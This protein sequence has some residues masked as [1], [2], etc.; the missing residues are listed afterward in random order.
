MLRM[1]RIVASPHLITRLII[2]QTFEKILTDFIQIP[3]GK[4]VFQKLQM[5]INK[6]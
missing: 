2:C 6:Y 3:P 1:F 4:N 5:H